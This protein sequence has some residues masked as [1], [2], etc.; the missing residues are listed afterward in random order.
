MKQS[1]V[2]MMVVN[3]ES[4]LLRMIFWIMILSTLASA[5]PTYDQKDP[6]E[7]TVNDQVLEDDGVNSLCTL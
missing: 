5:L 3:L 7:M 1:T 2:R 4:S 6:F